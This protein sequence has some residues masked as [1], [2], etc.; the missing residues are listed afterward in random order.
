M[1][2]NRELKPACRTEISP[3]GRKDLDGIF[4]YIAEN[5]YNSAVKFVED[6]AKKFR[7]L[8]ENP[9]LLGVL[10]TTMS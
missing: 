7:L 3:F 5:N 1:P 6:L 10:V 9:K 4:Q 8:A 2:K